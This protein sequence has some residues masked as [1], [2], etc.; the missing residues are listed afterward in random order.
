[1]TDRSLS[2]L[3]E[4]QTANGENGLLQALAILST[5]K[6]RAEPDVPQTKTYPNGTILPQQ[7][8]EKAI[9]I[10]KPY[11]TK[12]RQ[13][14]EAVSADSGQ[15]IVAQPSKK[16]SD[17]YFKYTQK[18][19]WVQPANGPQMPLQQSLGSFCTENNLDA[20]AMCA[21][22]RGKLY[23]HKGWKCGYRNLTAEEKD[24][25]W[26]QAKS[27]FWVKPPNGERIELKQTLKSFCIEHGLGYSPMI[28][29]AQAKYP[30]KHHKGWTCGYVMLRGGEDGEEGEGVEASGFSTIQAQPV[31]PNLLTPPL[32]APAPQFL[33]PHLMP[34]QMSQQMVAPQFVA[35]QHVAQPRLVQPSLLHPHQVRP[36]LAAATNLTSEIKPE[37]GRAE[38]VTSN[39]NTP[40]VALAVDIAQEP[41]V[42]T[43]IDT[44]VQKTPAEPLT[45]TA[46]PVV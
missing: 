33:A 32:L 26:G 8:G 15:A 12:K 9:R 46:F 45:T 14:Q 6:E 17:Q 3:P 37:P 7:P 2:D 34:Q 24:I 35:P 22:A 44:H 4:L 41:A 27:C 31:Q 40:M 20:S 38:V 5:M 23:T 43:S 11:K 10:Y 19:Y 39:P 18:R 21:V 13:I 36:H 28:K 42:Q 30:N 16:R 1:M 29:V 25:E